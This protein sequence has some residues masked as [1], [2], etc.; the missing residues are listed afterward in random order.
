MVHDIDTLLQIVAK[1]ENTTVEN[2]RKDIQHSIDLAFSNQ[3]ILEKNNFTKLFGNTKPTIEEFIN[4]S[5]G[6]LK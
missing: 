2:V 6:Q 4:K 5:V 1:Q 3:N